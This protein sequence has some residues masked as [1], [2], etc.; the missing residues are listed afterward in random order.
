[1]FYDFITK[2]TD[3]FVEKMS[4]A[5]AMQMLLTFLTKNIRIFQILTFKILTKRYLTTSLVLNNRAQIYGVPF[6]YKS[7]VL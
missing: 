5:F 6:C 3:V 4:A 7:L 2:H 1:M